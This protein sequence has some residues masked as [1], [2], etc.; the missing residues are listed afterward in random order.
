MIYVFAPAVLERVVA[1][2]RRIDGVEQVI[3]REGEEA[4]V[5]RGGEVLRFAPGEQ[6]ADLR[7]RRWTLSGELGVLDLHAR[8]GVVAQRRVPGRARARLGRDGVRARRGGAA[9]GGGRA[10]SSPT[11]AAPATSA[12]AATGRS[13][14]VTP[15]RR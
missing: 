12:A 14:P 7:G 11:G 15:T 8:D 10:S 4:V 5:A 1:R 3:W 2:A 6:I 9:D 13:R